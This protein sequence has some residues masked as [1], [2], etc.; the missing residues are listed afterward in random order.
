[1]QS[2]LAQANGFHANHVQN[3]CRSFRHWTGQDLIKPLGELPLAESLY[4]ASAV[5]LSH[6]TAPDPLFTY[7]NLSGQKLFEMSWATVLQT[8]SRH[9]AEP[10]ERSE[11]ARLMEAVTLRGFINDYRGVRVSASGKR[12]LIEQAIVWN[13]I[14]EEGALIGQAATFDHWIT[15]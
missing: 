15:L 8:P 6:N 2:E 9:S 12:F 10:V 3:L 5:V 11:R 7:A 1:M 13:V 4:H 14:D